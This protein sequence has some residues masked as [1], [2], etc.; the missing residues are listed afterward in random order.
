MSVIRHRDG[1]EWP[2]VVWE[3]DREGSASGRSY[4][5]R[6]RAIL[7]AW[8]ASRYAEQ[9]VWIEHRLP[10]IASAQGSEGRES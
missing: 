2:F 8:W 5:R 6:W 1:R 7:A 4:R 10:R 9:D 3:G